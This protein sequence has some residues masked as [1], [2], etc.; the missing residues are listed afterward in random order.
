[1]RTLLRIFNSPSGSRPLLVVT[2]FLLSSL[3][4]G[5]GLMSLLPV[6]AI[7]GGGEETTGTSKFVVEWLQA[8]GI[9]PEIKTLVAF[10]VAMM[11]AKVL[12]NFIAMR[13]ISN[14]AA[15]VATGL[16][17]RVITGVMRANWPFIVE[18]SKGNFTHS[19]GAESAR[20]SRAYIQA[21]TFVSL[22]AETLIYLLISLFISWKLA[23]AG[24]GLGAI[25]AGTLSFLIPLAR[26]AGQRQTYR[27]RE[28]MRFLSDALYNL[29]P[30]R[31]MGRE[32]D[33]SRILDKQ[34]NKVHR[35]MR[36]Q[37]LLRQGLTGL[38]EVMITIGFAVILLLVPNYLNIG[39]DTLI[40]MAIALSR[41]AK[42]IGKLQQT[43]QS[44]VV[45]ESAYTLIDDLLEDLDNAAE[46]RQ[47]TLKPSLED[48]IRFKDV[49][50]THGSARVLHDV[51]IEI[52]AKGLTVI[53]GPSGAGK[54]SIVDLILRFYEA[55]S[56]SIMVDD[57]P[58]ADL[59]LAAWRRKVGYVA[60][61][62]ILLQDSV[63]QN[64]MLGD[65]AISEEAVM[66][67]LDLAGARSFVDAL[68]EGV[69][70]LV[71]SE[72]SK[73][74]GGQRQRI[75]LARALAKN[76]ELLI[77][78]EATSALDTVTARAISSEVEQLKGMV[79]IIVITHRGEYLDV[80]DRVIRIEAGR[81]IEQSSPVAA[82]AMAGQR[83]AMPG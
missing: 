2:A 12:I 72:G 58:L 53:M 26:K 23:L 33:Y 35:A 68:P 56:G 10:A 77:L 57:K 81:I 1:M 29:K 41:T 4:E 52:P 63:L 78:D 15:E 43:Y 14:T 11:C 22:A 8:I 16:R 38:N 6:I 79:T 17:R 54:T 39:F 74:S 46:Q 36:Q 18:R 66:R 64:V 44:V 76:P 75:A 45:L 48:A 28:L 83:D 71:G 7:V 73:L 50:L 32:A 30:L 24:L 34:L 70:T 42:N 62:L 55:S 61:E 49:S 19:V 69:H 31:A 9:P 51:T 59:E 60:Q 37:I 67:A 13:F 5:I 25:V 21:A 20:A 80:A 40:I 27:K 82:A 3:T 47:G 65:P